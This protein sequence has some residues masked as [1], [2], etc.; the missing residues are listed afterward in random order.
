LLDQIAI[1]AWELMGLQPPAD[2]LA[3]AGIKPPEPEKISKEGGGS[4]WLLWTL[5]G[6]GV[7]GGGAAAAL[8]GGGDDTGGGGGTDPPPTGGGELPEPPNPPNPPNG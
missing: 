5:V 2:L 1:V 8:G 3:R 6:L 7:A 4:N